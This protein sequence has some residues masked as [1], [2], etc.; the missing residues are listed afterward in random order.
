MNKYAERCTIKK[1]GY[2]MCPHCT[3]LVRED[4]SNCYL[5][6]TIL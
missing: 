3:V 1:D 2:K 5:C 6:G 4:N